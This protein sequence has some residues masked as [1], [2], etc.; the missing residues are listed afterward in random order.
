MTH[1][2][3][4]ERTQMLTEPG[5]VVIDI[6]AGSNTTGMVA[7]RQDRRW[8]AI[9]ERKDY[10]AASAFR[11]V[12]KGL[13]ESQLRAVYSEVESGTGSDLRRSRFS[14]GKSQRSLVY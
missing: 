2:G 10:L 5:D 4:A 13:A 9:D 11:F 14:G 7:E 12:P 6:F 1:L 3:L 8:I